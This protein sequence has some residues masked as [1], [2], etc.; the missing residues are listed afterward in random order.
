MQRHTCNG[1]TTNC[2]PYKKA[3]EKFV[4]L[5]K[6]LKK[7]VL[8]QKVL[9]KICL[10]TKSPPFKKKAYFEPPSPKIPPLNLNTKKTLYLMK[11]VDIPPLRAPIV[12]VLI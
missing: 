11:I 1:R 9:T 10:T 8:L 5:Q 2:P 12:R 7:F 6:V 3:L 4:L